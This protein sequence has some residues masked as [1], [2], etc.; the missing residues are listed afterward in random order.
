MKVCIAAFAE[1]DIIPYIENYEN[2]LKEYEIDYEC[3]FWDRYNDLPTEKQE[4]EYTIHIKCMPGANR[5]GKI[6]PMY[7]YKKIV[8][9]IINKQN[10]THLIILT[11]LPGVLI[12]NLLFDKYKEKYILDI[13]D[14][15]Y[16]KYSFY[17]NIVDRLVEESYFTAISSKGFLKFLKNSK[18]IVPC[19]NIGVGFKEE[20]LA[21]DLKNKK[22]I[23]IGFV[24]G[25]RYYK[26]NCAL[27]DALANNPKYDLL[28][29]GKP[30]SDCDLKSYC[31]NK[32]IKNIFFEGEFK[33]IDKPKIYGK[34]DIINAIYGHNSLEVTTAVPNR[35]YDGLLF[36]KPIIVSEKTYLGKIVKNN[37]LG[38]AVD[39]HNNQD[40][41]CAIEKFLNQFENKKFTV[42][43][44]NILRKVR[45]EQKNFCNQI[46]QFLFEKD[47]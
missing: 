40:I 34:I 3:I 18:K 29:V 11:T 14:Y 2:I 27:I 32:N 36:K 45:L 5:L 22:K 24:G 43:C 6:I 35:L 19:H 16:E 31:I 1:R 12:S 26:E 23:T 41:N 4:N 15:T 30:N 37:C 25:V 21:Q 13:R 9:S 8:E 28:Y 46:K 39:T 10:Y 20:N 47:V 44:N 42:Y 38:V 7:K 17:K 33:N